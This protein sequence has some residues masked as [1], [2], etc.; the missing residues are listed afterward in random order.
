MDALVGHLEGRPIAILRLDASYWSALSSSRRGIGE[1]T[2]A[3]NHDAFVSLKAPT[4]CLLI[5]DAGSGPK[6]MAGVIGNP[7]AVTTIQSRVKLKRV[8]PI[9]PSSPQGLVKLLENQTHVTALRTRLAKREELMTLSA[10]LSGHIVEMLAKIDDN[11]VALRSISSSLSVPRRVRGNAALEEQSLRTALRAFGLPVDA[12]ADKVELLSE[13]ETAIARIS[14]D[15]DEEFGT[16][17]VSASRYV[18]RI[19]AIEDGFV[20]HEA[21]WVRG[22]D[23]VG[24]DATGRAIYSHRDERLEV[25][26][27]NRRSLEHALGVDLI[28]IN[29]IRR[30]VVMVQHKMLKPSDGSWVYRPDNQLDDEIARME[31][32][33]RPGHGGK[34]EYRLHPGVFYLKFVKRDASIRRGGILMPLDHFQSFVATPASR[35]PRGGIRVDY[36]ALQGRYMREQPFVD[37]IRAGYIGA[38]AEDTMHL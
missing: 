24:S 20:E 35:G 6:L 14:V 17:A 16:Y 21:R 8:F 11:H 19:H 28:Y 29:T 13:D 27:A 2:I 36:D 3:I 18:S 31:T 25:I 26:T 5:A 37:L 15:Q 4:L 32:F 38:Y 23:L 22:M 34:A 12:P 33:A 30:N 7:G 1:F 10:K 9:E